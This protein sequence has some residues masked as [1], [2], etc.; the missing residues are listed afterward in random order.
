MQSP[1][2]KEKEKFSEEKQGPNVK[3]SPKNQLFLY[4]SWLKG[5]FSLNHTAWLFKLSKS[6]VSRYLIT[7]SNFI[8]FFLGQISIWPPKSAIQETMPETF[9]NTYPSTRCIIDCT[10]LFCQPPSSL[11][12]QSHMYSHY[13]SHVTYKGFIGIALSGAITFVSQLY[14]GSI[15]DKEIFK[16]SGLLTKELW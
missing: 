1:K 5:G 13:K 4:F 7:W 6:T 11:S 16:K 9:K 12:S 3:L 10:E 8:Y 15:S 2:V 14:E